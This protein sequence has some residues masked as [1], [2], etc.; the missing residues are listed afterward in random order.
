[1]TTL[2][3]D[4]VN[5]TY[6]DKLFVAKN[7][8]QLSAAIRAKVLL[9]DQHTMPII[10]MSYTQSQLLQ[11]DVVLIEMLDNLRNLS[12]MKH[13]NCVV[14]V[15]PT[16][17]SISKVC[18]ELLNP[19]YNHY[20]LFFNN[21]ISKN[22]IE[23]IAEADE[24]EVVNQVIELYQDY[25]IANDNLFTISVP[26]VSQ[27]ARHTSTI[28]EAT[29][30]VS[31]LLSLKKCPM[32]KYETSSLDSKRLASEL[33]YYINSNSN[34]NLFDDLNRTSDVPPTL[35]ILDRKNDPI[36]PLV[37]PWTYQS[38]IHELIGINRNVVDIKESSEQ[39]T[40]SESQD[41]FFQETMYMNYGDLTDRFQKYVDEYKKQTKQSSIENLK[42]QDLSEFKK[43]LTRFPEFK[44]LSNN[45]LKHLNIIS[46]ID[47]QISGQ[48]LWAVGELQQTITCGL[49]NHQN[50]KTRLIDLIADHAVSTE[51]KV[52]LLLLYVAKFPNQQSDLGAML[53]KLNDPI[54]TS[55][56]P[57]I[58][59]T[60]LIKQFSRYFGSIKKMSSSESN[61]N[62]GNIGQIFNKNRIKI[63][64]LFNPNN[65]EDKHS[66]PK[67]DNIFM[68]YI[69]RLND[70]LAQITNP[71]PQNKQNQ[72]QNQQDKVDLATMVPDVVN[73]QYGDVSAQAAQEVIIYFK[74]GATYEEARLVHELSKINNRVKYIIG[75]DG[76][77]NSSQWLDKMSDI[78]NGYNEPAGGSAAAT[79]QQDRR[80]QL[81]EIL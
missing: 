64:Q 44:K 69:P 71:T 63:Q 13:L 41:K 66:M 8:T 3:L 78:V 74:G 36:S 53:A 11:Q 18:E 51:N 56:P 10:S 19:H 29:S 76:I 33:L 79:G 55:P 48:N 38:M 30:L 32:I 39:L 2:S 73:K 57:T 46:E 9:V 1:M 6:F 15:K 20:Q 17:E 31:L 47:K 70:V 27:S 35:L 65:D 50:I 54:T 40:L 24:Q 7:N 26:D 52:K 45:I 59:Q 14:Y 28:Q 4:K 21:S 42:T 58:T 5:Q 16:R 12:T 81:R 75:G 34:N 60:T 37:L 25:S 72:Q 22:D 67:T 23:R 80:S 68:Q 61:T 77:L 49:E 43:I 62:N